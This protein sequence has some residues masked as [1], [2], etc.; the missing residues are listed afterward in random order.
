MSIPGSG[1]PLLLA[2]TTAA[3]D[4]GYVIPKSLR[5]NPTDTASLSRTPSTAGNRRTW[6]VSLWLKRTKL[7][8]NNQHVLETA[9][10]PEYSGLWFAQDDSLE[11]RG[12]NGSSYTYRLHTSQK[13]RDP[14]AWYHIVLNFD[15]TA[16]TSSDRLAMYVNGVKVTDFANTVYPS[17]NHE[18]NWNNTAAHYIGTFVGSSNYYGGLIA[19]LQSVDGQALEPTD[20]GETRSSDGVWVPKEFTRTSPNDGTV[21]SNSVSNAANAATNLFDGS[22]ST[23]TEGSTNGT[24]VTWSGNVTEINKL[25]FY[26]NQAGSSR[27]FSVNGVDKL[28]LVPTSSAWFT[29]PGITTLT[30]FSF[31][32]GGS[33]NYVDLFAVRVNGEILQDGLN[34]PSG[35]GKNGFHLN[36]SDSST[37]EALGFDSAPTTPDPDPKK[38]FDVITYTG[39][40]GVQN[41][42]GALFEP[43]LVWIKERSGTDS[44]NANHVLVD[45]VRGRTKTLYPN[46]TSAETTGTAAFRS[47]NPDG[48]ALG[49]DTTKQRSNDNN[50]NYVAWMWRAGGPAVANTDGSVTSQVSASTDY[51]FSIVTFT[52]TGANA[53]VGHGLNTAPKWVM[54]KTRTKTD[55]WP[56]YHSGGGSNYQFFINQNDAGASGT[57]YFNGA[58]TSSVVN[59]GNNSGSNESGQPCLLYCWSEVSGFSKFGSY[60][61]NGS[62]TGPVVT[63]GFKVRWLLVKR[64]DSTS[65]WVILDTER[66]TTS[67]L[68]KS[69]YA[70]SSDAE[71]TPGQVWAKVLS[72]GFQPTATYGEINA[73]GG[74][75]LYAAFADRPGNNWDV[76]NIVTNEGLTTSKTQFD[77]VTYTGNGGTQKLGGP[78][79]SSSA[80]SG[81]THADGVTGMFDGSLSTRG[82][83]PSTDNSYKTL[84]DGAS[85][86]AST[87]IRIYWNGV[88]AGQ[89]YIRINGTT[90]LDDG[91][92]ALTPGWSTQSS[93]SGTI[94][95]IEVKTASSGSWSLAAV[96]VDGTILIDGTGPGLKFQPD[97]IW[98]KGRS[99]SISHLLYDSVRGYGAD[100]ELVPNGSNAEGAAGAD[101]TYGYV[102]AVNSSGFTVEGGSDADNGYTNKTNATYVAW[103]WKAGGTA[104]SN[105]DGSITSSVSANAQY[106]FSIVSYTGTGSASTIGHGLS[107][108]PKMILVKP[109]SAS[110]SWQTFHVGIGN[111]GSTHLNS[112]AGVDTA[113]S[114]WNNTDPTS[115]VF[116]VG[117][118]NTVNQSGT[119]F[120]A[121]CF[122]DVPGYQRIGSY[123]GNGSSTGPVVVTGFKPRFLLIKNISSGDS[124]NSNWVLVDTQR[125]VDTGNNTQLTANLPNSE[126][127]GSL[128]GMDILDNGFQIK[129][130]LLTYNTSGSTYIYLAIGDDEIGSDE[131]CLVDVPNAV[132]ADAGATDTTGGYQRGNYCTINPLL[133]GSNTNIGNGNLE[134]NST[135]STWNNC[136]G[137][138]AIPTSGKWFWEVEAGGANTQPG[139]VPVSEDLA[140]N[141][142][143]YPSNNLSFRG[144]YGPGGNKITGPGAGSTSYG[145]SFT[146]GDIVGIAFDADTGSLTFYKNGVSQGVAFTG[147]T[148]QYIPIFG[149]FDTGVQKINFGQ[150]RFKY[151]M[152]SGY[153]ALN[154]TALPAATIADG[155]AQFETKLYT[156]NGGSKRIGG[157][158][159]AA[160]SGVTATGTG[161]VSGISTTYPITGA[162]DGV[163]STYL[164]T[165]AANISSNAAVLTVTF[166]SDN[167][168]SYSSSVVLEVWCSTTDTVKVAINGGAYQT[169]SASSNDWQQHTVASGSGTI[170]EIKVSR[171]KG[172]TNAGAAELR[173]IIVDGVQ[174]LDGNGD[175]LSFQPDFVWVKER[176]S[177]SS[178]QLTNVISGVGKR[179]ATDMTNAEYSNSEMVKS[180][181]SDGFTIGNHGGHNENN[182][183]YAAW[184]W[185]AGSSTVSNTD[186]SITSS[187]R[188][189]PSAGFSIL[190]F[191][192][193]TSNS[194]VGHGLNAKPDLIIWKKRSG[195]S[196]WPIYHSAL[197]ATK[198]LYLNL[199]NA[200]STGS[201]FWNNTEPTSS[202]I[203]TKGEPNSMGSAGDTVMYVFT[204]VAGYSAFGSY[205]G[206]GSADG[207]FV[208]CGFKPRWIMMKNADTG[209]TYY[210]WR[211]IDTARHTYNEGGNE[212]I[213]PTLFANL[214]DAEK[215]WD[216]VD[217][218]SNG[219]KIKDS[220]VSLNQS[221]AT[222]IFI[223]FA[224]NPFQANGG[225][226]R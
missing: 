189:N 25:E 24:A 131:D 108:T 3:A 77:V 93:F 49:L 199:T 38:G 115:S 103:C 89:R 60:T 222:Q 143:T 200:A 88:G 114:Y 220:S 42:G 191:T 68:A 125:D 112:T 54:A 80:D 204:A 135:S 126:Y 39:N 20:F 63:T 41:I 76:N 192:N 174:L 79:F 98:L 147:L 107:S 95:K 196:H 132:T 164:A 185:N 197:G 141:V 154:T 163:T 203:T 65:N 110:G 224:E 124:T 219:F 10:S 90:E 56:V 119:T 21:W 177:T 81:L 26:G 144:Y 155:S 12:F 146:T 99:Y 186:G 213:P 173:A 34:N 165:N 130:T 133:K 120:I 15:S 67:S 179:L 152:P 195:T 181:N 127:E 51:G 137:T 33:G 46:T 216:N 157:S 102:S 134:I 190:T 113:S 162:F 218:L 118:S 13:F 104:V 55:G 62:S 16:S 87:G 211:I 7:G 212:D 207:P 48:F 159:T 59:L 202:V 182:K 136:F 161:A 140:G 69:L 85:I 109:R 17:K 31:S 8:T 128:I 43:G 139:I 86:S 28:S 100:K 187:V 83:A 22:T 96:E 183:T 117:S 97:L 23:Y 1:S 44:G 169:V 111:T 32:R 201:E 84:T 47:F 71:Y 215:D 217:I 176:N 29:V 123:T 158:T 214:S 142:G 4:A 52:G 226:A 149:T 61:G 225:L 6:T 74:S 91:S 73:S 53:T 170:T 9:S 82:G 36:F 105:T 153:A 221:G 210:D 138:I 101:S 70:D 50:D 18:S 209:G 188:A 11:F 194:T 72:D 180:L 64:T 94:N 172:N 58:P 30:A 171:Q 106:G 223:A 175:D 206:N 208:Y 166:P 121:Y 27:T 14:S 37:N 151:P 57:S 78:V 178:H 116:T 45:S 168:P 92:A 5:F 40:G 122:A 198:Y 2:T 167:Q 184:L 75:Y 150:M 129:N 193:T 160:S 66:N 35:Y 205:E 148:D 156:G 145:S 19:D